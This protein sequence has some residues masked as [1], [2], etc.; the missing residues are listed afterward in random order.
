MLIAATCLLLMAFAATPAPPPAAISVRGVRRRFRSLALAVRSWVSERRVPQPDLGVLVA[1]TATRLRAG[2]NPSEAWRRT[3]E[4]AGISGDERELDAAGVPPGLRRLGRRRAGRRTSEI[5]VALA[6]TVALC[7][8][9]YFSGAP[10]AEVLDSCAEGITEAAEAASARKVA[11]AGPQTSAQMIAWM[12]LIGLV[13]GSAL[14]AEPL[15]FLLGT[16]GGRGV[17][18]L[19]CILEIAGIVWVRRLSAAAEAMAES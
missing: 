16:W 13:L 3:L 19:A 8:L 17:L 2:A 7:R 18:G 9:S 4:R 5:Q 14:G 6:S 15:G 12:P 11:L 1:E 10:M